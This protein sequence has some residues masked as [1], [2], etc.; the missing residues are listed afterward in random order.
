M[1]RV[2]L[3]LSSALLVS[4]L[5]T[6]GFAE[7]VKYDVQNCFAGPIQITQEEGLLAG[8][9]AV[10]GIAP[11]N[12]TTLERS[13]GRCLGAFSIIDGQLDENGT[14]EWVNATGDKAFSVYARKG[15]PAKAEGT[16]HFVKGTGKFAGIT[17]GGKYMPIGPFPPAPGAPGMQ[18]ASRSNPGQISRC[19]QTSI[20]TSLCRPLPPKSLKIT[21]P[22]VWDITASCRVRSR[23]WVH[24]DGPTPQVIPLSENTWTPPIKRARGP[25]SPALANGRG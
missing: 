19:S 4:A 14:C 18:R 7:E 17:G 8:S 6:Q 25:S 13:S 2:T 23:T 15:D 9:Y 11:G 22:T 21:R 1:V 16:Y 10:L 20:G 12:G 5:S 24:A 3:V